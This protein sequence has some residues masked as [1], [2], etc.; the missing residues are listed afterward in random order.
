M[1]VQMNKL[2]IISHKQTIVLFT[3]LFKY[4]AYP[5]SNQFPRL[6]NSLPPLDRAGWLLA[7]II[8]YSIN[9]FDL[10]DDS[11]TDIPEDVVRQSR[12]VGGHAID[13]LDGSDRNHLLVRSV[14]PHD[15]DR[16]DR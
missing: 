10:A 6:N 14:I 8:N 13:A 12:P 7:D 5:I 16:L 3:L 2:F 9:A 15:A 11:A 1:K 4:L